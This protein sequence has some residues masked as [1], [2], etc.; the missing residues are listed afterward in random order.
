MCLPEYNSKRVIGIIQH[1]FYEKT[2]KQMCFILSE[3]QASGKE[4]RKYLEQVVLN[5]SFKEGTGE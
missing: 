4:E 1:F 2:Q 5:V 3:S